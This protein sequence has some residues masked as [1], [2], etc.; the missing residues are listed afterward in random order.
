MILIFDFFRNPLQQTLSM[1]NF[2]LVILVIFANPKLPAQTTDSAQFYFVKGM[3]EKSARR[4]LVA[5]KHFDKAIELYPKFTNAYIENGTVNLEMRKI[6]AAMGNFTKAN[7]IEP[8][9]PL[10]IIESTSLYFNNLKFQKTNDKTQECKDNSW[11][12]KNIAISN[13]HLEEYGKA[14]MGLQKALAKSPA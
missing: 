7:L 1:K 8:A 14:I 12:K 4:Y 11:T 9:N 3:E 5:A 13:Y 10:A 6:D 2:L